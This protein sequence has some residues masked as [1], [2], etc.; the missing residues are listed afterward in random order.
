[1]KRYR[2]LLTLLLVASMV[3]TFAAQVGTAKAQKAT[4]TFWNGFTGPDRPAVEAL[5]KKFNDTHPNIE[6]KME[7]SPWDSL[8]QNLLSTMS[9]GQGPDVVGIHFQFL[10]QY[11]KSGYVLDL[12]DQYKAGSELDPAHFPPALVELMKYDGKFYAA[13]MNY[14][15]LMMYYN[16]DL[17]KAAGLDPEKPPTDW[18]SW[19]DA[20]KKLTKTEAGQEQYGLA[21]GEHDTIPNWP[22]FLWANGGDVV[23]KDGKSALADP[24]TIE[25][26]K[27]WTDLVIK[28]KISPIGLGGAEADK[29]FQTGKAAMEITGPWMVNGFT[30]AKLNF[31]VAPVPA[32]PAGKV[33]V[34]DTV[35]MM[36]N[37]ST[38][39]KDAALEFVQYWNSKDSQAYFAAQT[40]FPPARTDIT[41]NADLKANQWSQQFASVA[42]ESRF[43]LPGQEKFAQIDAEVFIPMIQKITQGQASVEDAAKEADKA[44]NDL[45]ASK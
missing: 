2:A 18:T 44:L 13:P 9:A 41:D 15:T 20:I 45:L 40:G 6:V 11:A 16:K 25:A 23:G 37:K 42:P 12:T 31:G 19:I 35:L 5:V 14:A 28:N 33:T 17:F 34:A 24:K 27:T 30:E 10:P 38:K 39:S 32:G 22:I 29:L 7:I 36:V 4:L 8:M 26:L 3:L 43:Y 21:I 1:M